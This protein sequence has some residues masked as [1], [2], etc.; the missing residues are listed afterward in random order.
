MYV[1]VGMSG[2]KSKLV[3]GVRS[4][5]IAKSDFEAISHAYEWAT[6]LKEFSVIEIWSE[7]DKRKVVTLEV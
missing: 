7:N 6:D 2:R 4:D 1:Y 5:P 3:M